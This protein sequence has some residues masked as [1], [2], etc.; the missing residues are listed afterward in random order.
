[1]GLP[2]PKISALSPLLSNIN[3][4]NTNTD[5][6]LS[7]SRGRIK[8]M[9]KEEKKNKTINRVYGSSFIPSLKIIG[10]PLGSMIPL[11]VWHCPVVQTEKEGWLGGAQ[12]K[13]WTKWSNCRDSASCDTVR[14]SFVLV[15]VEN[16][17]MRTVAAWS[18][19]VQTLTGSHWKAYISPIGIPILYIKA[20]VVNKTVTSFPPV[21]V[22][23]LSSAA[24]LRSKSVQCRMPC[25]PLMLGLEFG[26]SQLP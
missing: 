26:F 12:P 20:S 15:C 2:R 6:M 14:H 21:A 9:N 17:T 19:S 22:F 4:T 3:S 16:Q 18:S 10:Y 24:W 23:Q 7:E 13:P 11:C 25:K 1:M 8:T 5:H